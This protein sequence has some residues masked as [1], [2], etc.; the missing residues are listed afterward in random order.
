MF[1]SVMQPEHFHQAFDIDI[2]VVGTNA[3]AYFALWRDLEAAC[4]HWTIDLREINQLSHFA[5]TVHRAGKLIYESSG[6]TPYSS[7]H[8]TKVEAACQN[9]LELGNLKWLCCI[10]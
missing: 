1:G 9:A 3:A 8:L 5:D 6:S 4:C 2:A 10:N 7:S